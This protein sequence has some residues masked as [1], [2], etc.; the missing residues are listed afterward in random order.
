MPAGGGFRVSVF[1][2]SVTAR[3]GNTCFSRV[4]ESSSKCVH[5]C[6]HSQS[7][8]EL[9]VYTEHW[10]KPTR[11]TLLYHNFTNICD[12][13]KGFQKWTILCLSRKQI[14]CQGEA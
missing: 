13:Q 3:K 14:K 5:L 7:L 2:P 6:L 8:L 10:L 11:E 12:F 4:W 1:V 9:F